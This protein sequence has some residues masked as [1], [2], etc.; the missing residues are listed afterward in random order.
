MTVATDERF[1]RA[2]LS[3]GRRGRGTTS[4]NPSVGCVLV[5]ESVDGPR[6]VA[7]GWTASGGRPHA[8]VVALEAASVD[9][10]GATAYVTLEPCAHHGI[11]PPCAQ[12]LIDAG[13]RRV[14]TAIEDP[15]SRVAGRGHQMLR[16]AGIELTSGILADE[17]RRDHAGFFSRLERGR[18]HVVLKLAV[19]ADGKIAA[20]GSTAP[21]GITEAR[22]RARGHL[23]RARSDAILVGRNTALADDPMLTCRLPGL[24]HRSALRIVADSRLDLCPD[25]KLATSAEA[26]PVW[27][28]AGPEHAP[29]RA[30]ALE[31]KGVRVVEVALSDN[32]MIDL[33]AALGIVGTHGINTLMVEGGA[34]IASG[35]LEA[36][37]VDEVFL[38]RSG[39]PVGEDGVDALAHL[40][41]DAVTSSARFCLR[42]ELTLGPD[43][44][45]AYERDRNA[46]SDL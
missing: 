14:V 20:A 9:V 1:M 26:D 45:F 19:S 40:S 12:A 32:G 35:L 31:A 44:M 13:V 33:P 5:Q 42:D 16:D 27:V 11:T 10:R 39:K 4:P 25:S 6:V 8:E 34:R 17:A 18:P 22:A 21:N 29:E 28:L 38:F 30:A 2:A 37:L 15:D 7:R 43:R 36:D 24:E 23:I 41:L 46:A 3:L